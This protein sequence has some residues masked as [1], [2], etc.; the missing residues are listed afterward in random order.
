MRTQNHGNRKRRPLIRYLVIALL[1][2]GVG[3]A[4][5]SDATRSVP[6]ESARIEEGPIRAYVEER[7]RTSVPRIYHITMPLPG[8]VLPV[9]L[10]EGDEVTKGQV[11]ATLENI[12]WEE[13]TISAAEMLTAM[14]SALEAARAEVKASEVRLDFTEWM[15]EAM[16]KA[17]ERDAAAEM[18]S[19]EAEWHYLDSMV[20]KEESVAN[21][22]ITSAFHAIVKLLPGIVKRNLGRTRIE[23]PVDGVVL[24]RHVA[25][26]KTLL[27]GQPVLDIGNLE[28]LQVT[29]DILTE[30]AVRILPGQRV[31]IF[32]EAVGEKPIRGTVKR[33]LPEAFTKLSSLGVEQQRVAV[34]IAFDPADLAALEKGGRALGLHYRVRV[35]VITDERPKVRLI[36][37]TALFRGEG[38]GWQ[39]FRINERG[40]AEGVG[41]EIGLMNDRV[42]EVSSGLDVGDEV[43]LAPESSLEEGARVEGS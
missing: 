41:L 35:R 22:H 19:R 2:A 21:L 11:V 6:V 15:H 24:K 38:G 26:E 5:Y 8:R 18:E 34:E 43:I 13:A 17:V 12:E 36:P 40:R 29:G 37:R 32:G 7:A 3:Y 33:V 14:N 9:E 28:D 4:I 10:R 42:A 23:S 27:P 1:I 16:K 25:N 39:A 20:K 30:E 31:E